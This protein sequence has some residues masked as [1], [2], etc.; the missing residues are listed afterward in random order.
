MNK[1]SVV[2]VCII[3]D[4]ADQLRLIARILERAGYDVVT[5]GNLTTGVD[6]IRETHP[7]VVLCDCEL[8]DGRGADL[9]DQI[10]Q[11]QQLA[12]IH[13]ILMSASAS[14][15]LSLEVLNARADDYLTK[16][17]SADELKARVRVWVRMWTM[18]EQLRRAAI[19]DGLT[20]LYNHDHFNSILESELARSRRYGKALALI[21]LDMDFFKAI[22]DTYGHLAGNAALAE[23]SRIL[24][25][26]V[27]EIDSV[28]RFGGEEFAIVL[29][30][31]TVSDAAQA[32][33]RIRE[34]LLTT[35]HVP[36]LRNHRVTASFGVADSEDP[37]VT[38]AADLVDLA[39]RALYAAKRRGRNQVADGSNLDVEPRATLQTGEVERL[40]RRIE[41]LSVRTKDVYVQSIAALLQAL[42]E[43]DPFTARHAMNVAFY[44]QQ[45]AAKMGC[46]RSTIKSVHNAALLHDIGK[47]GVPDGIL[48]KKT[49]LADVERMIMDQVPI[50][51]ARIVDQ[52]RILEAEISIIRHQREFFDGSGRPAGLSADQI[53]VG[54]RILG[55]ADAF[56]AMTTDRVY[57]K[58][59][60]VERAIDELH[61]LSGRQFDPQAVQAL[62]ECFEQEREAWRQRVEKTID[63]LRIPEVSAGPPPVEQ[64][65]SALPA[66]V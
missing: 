36:A 2:D 54:S 10:R 27:R 38:C 50:I 11:D 34:A 39:D 5:A 33:E 58:R 59:I 44:A 32:A 29:P 49:P 61:R 56:D 43:K 66:T 12:D 20:G 18:Y 8:P 35:F 4:D 45:V 42:D 57:R 40:Q 13:I 63:T 31:S 26:G 51:G 22:N 64:I 6:L 3:E 30:E 53:P 25:N 9:C 19:T 65:R 23:V 24:Q 21:M 17:K 41:A 14:Q 15:N 52:L 60:S 1:P 47:I 48:M 7:K 55:V 46:S 28:A 16:P 62:S 37:R